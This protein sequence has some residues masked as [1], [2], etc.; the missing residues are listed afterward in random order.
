MDAVDQLLPLCLERFGR[1]DIRLDHE[2][3]D[4]LVR[5]EAIGHDDPVDRSVRLQQYLAFGQV[6]FQRFARIAAALQHLVGRPQRLQHAI[7][8]R[9]PVASSG[10]PS[11]AACACG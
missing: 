8:D 7:E 1:G 11:I 4:Q 5:I 6:E 9:T 2:F 10:E 3:F